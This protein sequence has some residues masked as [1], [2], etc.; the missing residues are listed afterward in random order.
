MII[1][2][3]RTVSNSYK[4]PFLILKQQQQ[5]HKNQKQHQII[6][7]KIENNGKLPLVTI[8]YG[9]EAESPEII[10]S[11]K[12]KTCLPSTRQGTDTKIK[13]H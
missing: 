9:V 7:L 2:N 11:N 6:L 3:S 4:E 10:D 12:N 1:H 8:S 13:Y 5:Q